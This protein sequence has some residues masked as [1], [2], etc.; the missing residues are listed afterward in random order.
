MRRLSA[1]FYSHSSLASSIVLTTAM[2]LYASLVMGG[3]SQCFESQLPEGMKVFGLKFGLG[4]EYAMSFFNS[5]DMSGL[6]CYRQLIALW[7]NIFPITYSLMYVSWLSYIFKRIPSKGAWPGIINLFPFIPAAMD[8]IENIFE[9][10]LVDYY[11]LNH[12]LIESQVMIS[13]IISQF[14]WIASYTNYLIIITGVSILLYQFLK[15]K[16]M[17]GKNL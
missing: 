2:V 10:K 14:K 11:I 15:K 6:L 8:W 4:Y 17:K 1:L 12:E 16:I 13:S 5:L 9:L 7:D 3:K